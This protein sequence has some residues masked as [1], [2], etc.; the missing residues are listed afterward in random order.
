MNGSCSKPPLRRRFP[1]LLALLALALPGGRAL[2][3]PSRCSLG[4]PGAP[5][6]RVTA[7]AAGNTWLSANDAYPA[8]ALGVASMDAVS[9][10]EPEMIGQE[11]VRLQAAEAGFAVERSRPMYWIADRIMAPDH[12]DWD[13]TF[14]RFHAENPNPGSFFFD[15]AT[16]ALYAAAG[17]PAH[18]TWVLTDGQTEA[19]VY[20]IGA[21][22]QGRPRRIFWTDWPYQAPPVNLAGT[23]VRFYGN[24]EILTPRYGV[25][26]NVTGGISQVITNKITRG[27]YLDQTTKQLFAAGE[28]SGQ[29]A[30]GLL[31][32]RHLRDPAAGAGRRVARPQVIP[33]AGASANPCVRRRGL[34]YRRPP[35]AADRGGS[36]RTT[37]APTSIS[38]RR[39]PTVPRM[40]TSIPLRPTVGRAGS[41]GVLEWRRTSSRFNGP[42]RSAS[43]R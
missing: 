7:N 2:A 25:V 37:A 14:A 43:T 22:A 5:V 41:R 16:P 13:A 4:I 15:T 28:L 32:L 30:D 3:E 19:H 17:G 6:L 38:T 36:R 12:V 23:F 29:V 9:T 26:T 42:S 21:A 20:I 27:L 35:R 33:M 40:A 1:C 18:F 31:R 10:L 8:M 11:V 24:P 34:Q 39:T